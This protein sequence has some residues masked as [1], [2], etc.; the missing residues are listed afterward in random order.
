MVWCGGKANLCPKKKKKKEKKE[1]IVA[2]LTLL[3]MDISW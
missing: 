3:P 1:M 2:L